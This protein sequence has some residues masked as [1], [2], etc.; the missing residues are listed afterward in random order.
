ME[1]SLSKFNVFLAIKDRCGQS[2]ESP[3]RGAER[4]FANELYFVF[5]LQ[6]KSGLHNI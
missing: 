6:K 4:D 3:S 5:G 1:N 2:H